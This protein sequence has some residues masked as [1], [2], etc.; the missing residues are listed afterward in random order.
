MCY[1]PLGIPTA[2]FA[3]A[4]TDAVMSGHEYATGTPLVM[5]S[6]SCK[7]LNGV[8]SAEF[9]RH[10]AV[11]VMLGCPGWQCWPRACISEMSLFSGMS[12]ICHYC[13]ADSELRDVR[14]IGYPK[15]AVSSTVGYPS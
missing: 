15:G 13:G 7:P 10:S 3:S 11:A 14:N 6:L 4:S 8:S 9:L 12:L 5:V 2:S 1:L